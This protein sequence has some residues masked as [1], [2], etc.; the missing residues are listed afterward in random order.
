MPHTPPRLPERHWHTYL[1]WSTVH[2]PTPT[3]EEARQLC[4]LWNAG[5]RFWPSHVDSSCVGP[6]PVFVEIPCSH[7]CCCF[8]VTKIITDCLLYD[9][10]LFVC[11][12]QEKHLTAIF[13]WSHSIPYSMYVCTYVVL[14]WCQC[15]VYWRAYLCVVIGGEHCKLLYPG[16]DMYVCT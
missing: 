8:M 9:F 6:L 14:I 13:L 12:W 11:D 5:L 2:A 3:P 15:T 10:T 1:P 4:A 7:N 16:V